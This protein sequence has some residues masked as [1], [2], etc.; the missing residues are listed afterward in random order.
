MN[1]GHEIIDAIIEGNLIM[2]VIIEDDGSATFVWTANAAE[3]LEALICDK[4][5]VMPTFES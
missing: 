2:E 3:Q 1:I 4:I 5:G